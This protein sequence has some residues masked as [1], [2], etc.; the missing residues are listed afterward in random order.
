MS[1]ISDTNEVLFTGSK[2]SSQPSRM[3]FI[4]WKTSDIS[5]SSNNFFVYLFLNFTLILKIIISAQN[6]IN[7][8]YIST[9]ITFQRLTRKR[10]HMMP[11]TK[12]R[13]YIST[14]FY[15][16]FFFLNDSKNLNQFRFILSVYVSYRKCPNFSSNNYDI[17]TFERWYETV[18]IL[19]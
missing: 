11:F 17:Y 2:R 15:R 8:I 6:D 3:H 13:E 16:I 9:Y 10:H 4:K 12:V 7:Y 1:K 18:F 5:F 14:E 19:G